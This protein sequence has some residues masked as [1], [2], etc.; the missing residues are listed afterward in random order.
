[1]ATDNTVTISGNT[2]REPEMRF[3]RTGTA[4]AN[5]A[6]AVNRSRKV[7]DEW[8]TETSFIDVTCWSQLAENVAE[9]VS[10]GARVTVTGR[11]EQESWETEAGDKRSKIVVVADDVALSLK[12]ATGSVQKTERGSGQQRETV[13]AA[14]AYAPGEEPF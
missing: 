2:T 7:G 6:V 14:A 9:S 4:V 1:M 13:P 5:F 11:M 3:T 10:K 12:W 8:E